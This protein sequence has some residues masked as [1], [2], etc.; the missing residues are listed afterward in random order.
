MS[1]DT[2]DRIDWLKRALGDVP[3]LILAIREEVVPSLQPSSEPRVSGSTEKTIAPLNVEPIDA[4]DALWGMVCALAIDYAQRSQNWRELPDAIDRQWLIPGSAEFAVVGFK[5][6]D[7]D[8]IYS[9][10]VEVT[11]YLIEHAFPLAINKEYSVPVDELVAA[12]VAASAR[13]ERGPAAVPQ[14]QHRHKCPRCLKHGVV[15]VYS[16]TGE[17]QSLKCERC[18]AER[19]F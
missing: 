10:V 6:I 16:A 13:Q 12:I 9:D 8:R 5:S 3:T 11:R 1:F 18:G 19:K 14:R 7:E 15:P 17:I 4:A 2:F